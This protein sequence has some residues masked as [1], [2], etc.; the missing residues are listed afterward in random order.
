M[1][2]RVLIENLGQD[3]LENDVEDATAIELLINPSL[4]GTTWYKFDKTFVTC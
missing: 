4:Y 2:K 3:G 1:G